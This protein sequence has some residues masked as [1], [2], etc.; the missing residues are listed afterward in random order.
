MSSVR[1]AK[2]SCQ[3]QQRSAAAL[4]GA[5]LCGADFI[6]NE[7]DP[8]ETNSLHCAIRLDFNRHSTELHALTFV[9]CHLL[10]AFGNSIS[11]STT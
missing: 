9:L 1:F 4:M 10:V 8:K 6:N 2:T 5:I 7:N 3:T 11:Y